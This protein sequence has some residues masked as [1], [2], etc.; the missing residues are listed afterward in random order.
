MHEAFELL[1]PVAAQAFLKSFPAE[2][3]RRGHARFREGA[4]ESLIVDQPGRFYSAVVQDAAWKN[5]VS[6]SYDPIEGWD[7]VCSC[8]VSSDCAHVFAA[9]SALLAEYRMVVVRQLSAGQAGAGAALANLRAGSESSEDEDLGERLISATGRA[10]N[11]EALRFL[12]QLHE[13]YLRCRQTRQISYWELQQLGFPLMNLGWAALKIWPAFP[14]SEHE[15]WLYLA[16]F[17]QERNVELPDFMRP[18]TDLSVIAERLTRW[19]RA[20]EV[21]RWKQ[22]LGNLQPVSHR[23]AA[24]GEVDLRLVIDDKDARLQ[25]QRP[26]QPDFEPL[27][28]TQFRQLEDDYDEGR[29]SLTP[30]GEILWQSFSQILDYGIKI[31]LDD[32]DTEITMVLDVADRTLSAAEIKLLLNAKGGLCEAPGQRLAAASVLFER[33][34]E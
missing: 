3:Q 26:G 33:R 24:R 29:L 5:E 4:V 11:R 20:A 31:D 7:G 14:N 8:P 2:A 27:K 15:F 34:G 22:T 13:V 28:Q 6:L 18:I 1:D 23:P 19:R 9:M 12:K 30:E 17:L 25:W 21:E 16:N 32:L 10:L